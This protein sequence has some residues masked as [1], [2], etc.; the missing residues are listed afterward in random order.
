[1]RIPARVGPVP[2]AGYGVKGPEGQSSGVLGAAVRG[3]HRPD[4]MTSVMS[5]GRILVRMEVPTPGWSPPLDRAAD[6]ASWGGVVA[7]TGAG[8]STDSGIPDYRGPGSP[9]R[10]PMSYADFLSDAVNRQR[11]WAR[12]HVGW[13]R[14]SRA[15]PNPGHHALAALEAAGVVDS[16]ITQNVD[17]LHVEAGSR[18]VVELHGRIDEVTCLACRAVTTRAELDRRLTDLNADWDAAAAPSVA[19]VAPDGDAVI[20]D[21]SGFR[22]ADCRS[23]G[24]VLKPHLV[25][26]GESVPR[27]RVER[28][29][30]LVDSAR[31]LLVAGS[32]LTVFSGRRFVVRARRRGIP[33]IVVN[34]GATRCDGDL[35]PAVDVRIDAG[36]S[37][38]LTELARA[39]APRAA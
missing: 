1:M 6:I 13:R 32:S 19:E 33:V 11:Y 23:C 21:T 4:A 27:P 17:R 3:T 35:D 38:V 39:V 8:L 12:S 5:A 7:L 9:G 26:F 15:R 29:Q 36:C 18:R 14:M 10:R 37:P 20:G 34:R 24:G 30:A 28:C 25:F 31:S 22:V 2:R 16:V